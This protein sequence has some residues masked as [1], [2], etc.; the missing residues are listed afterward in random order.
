MPK[1]V[2]DTNHLSPAL[3]RVSPLRDRIWAEARSGA[4]F[5]T[6]WSVLCELEA[7]IVQTNKPRLNRQTLDDLLQRI[8]IWPWDWQMVRRYGE[9]FQL[10]KGRGRVM[11]IVDIMLAAHA[12]NEDAIVL[13]TDRDFEAL[14]EV[15]TEN[16]IP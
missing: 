7:G 6:C 15:R 4:R 8:R 10:V 9:L 2:L 13:T 5:A 12:M 16:W 14:P 3:K 1:Y 11:S